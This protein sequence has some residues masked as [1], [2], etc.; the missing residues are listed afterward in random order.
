MT[1]AVDPEWVSMEIARRRLKLDESSSLM[2]IAVKNNLSDGLVVLIVIYQG[3]EKLVDHPSFHPVSL[4]RD[5]A[6]LQML[7]TSLDE[8]RAAFPL[9]LIVG[10]LEKLHCAAG[11]I[12]NLLALWSHRPDLYACIFIGPVRSR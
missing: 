8:I 2:L 7:D 9:E 4:A 10:R 12:E 11:M 3:S 1:D 5:R 6:L